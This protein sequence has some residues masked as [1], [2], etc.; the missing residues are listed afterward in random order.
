MQPD[1]SPLE[2]TP[3]IVTVLWVMVAAAAAITPLVITPHGFDVFRVGKDATF[4]SLAMLIAALLA[5]GALTTRT[6]EWLAPVPR[7]PTMLAA[8]AVLWTAI[9]AIASERPVVSLAKPLTVFAMAAFFVAAM[10]AMRGQRLLVIVIGLAPGVVNGA[11]ALLQS[12]NVWSPWQTE[13]TDPRLRTTALLGNPNEVGSYFVIPAVAAFA[14]MVAWR[15]QRWWLAIV[16]AV[17]AGG[18]VASQSAAPFG[19]LL[20]G[21]VAVALTVGT[22]RFRIVAIAI[23]VL[24][25]AAA[26]LH[27]GSRARA[28]RLADS[29]SDRSLPELTSFRIVPFAAAMMMFR[30]HPLLG[31]GP[32]SFGALYMP[33]KERVD[34]AYPQWIRMGGENYGEVHNDHLQLLAETGLPG[35]AL[36]V[37]ALLLLARISLRRERAPN[38]RVRFA[39]TFALPA[40]VAFA[41]LTLAQ[42]PMQLT[43]PM[44]SALYFTAMAFVWED[45][46]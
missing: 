6:H 9:T 26:L 33:Y 28:Q 31:A 3:R 43:A 30:D 41:V 36:Y 34:V 45:A 24:L 40:A 37:A 10:I 11:I 14:A 18:V 8:A 35:Y 12:T 27:P 23:V 44:V 21:L 38:E 2:R 13:V 29:L 19:A 39:R 46:Q 5:A 15:R 32:G 1:A 17:L 25:I 22:K 4:L 7:V 42:F 16:C 20:A